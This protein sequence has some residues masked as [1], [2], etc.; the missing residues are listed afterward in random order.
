[1]AARLKEQRAWDT[2]KRKN[3]GRLNLKRVENQAATGMGDVVGINKQGTAFWIEMKALD[4]WPAREATCPLR[5]AF[6]P[7]QLGFLREWKSWRG[8]AFVLLRVGLEFWLLNPDNALPE[9]NAAQLR[10]SA[11][12]RDLDHIILFLEN[13]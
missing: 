12:R 2:F 1:M 7:G 13:I 10:E 11:I 9:Y 8:D 4:A 6:E 3:L 5:D